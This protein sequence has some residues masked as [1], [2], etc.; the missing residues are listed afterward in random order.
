MII[1]IIVVLPISQSEVEYLFDDEV[2]TRKPSKKHS[3][4]VI[5]VFTLP[6]TAEKLMVNFILKDNTWVSNAPNQTKISNAWSRAEISI[7]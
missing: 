1:A 3:R 4:K 6:S 2:E 7:D 5:L